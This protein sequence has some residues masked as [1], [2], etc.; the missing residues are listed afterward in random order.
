[1]KFYP[2]LPRQV[3]EFPR[4]L[5]AYDDTVLTDSELMMSTETECHRVC[6]RRRRCQRRRRRC[7][8]HIADADIVPTHGCRRRCKSSSSSRGRLRLVVLLYFVIA[9]VGATVYNT[10]A[11]TMHMLY[12]LA[13]NKTD[14]FAFH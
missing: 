13:R 4:D 7:G 3:E 8:H 5:L 14:T 11:D 2:S 1:M 9:V 6:R 10:N 12:Q